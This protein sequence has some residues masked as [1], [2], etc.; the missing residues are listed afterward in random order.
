MPE[1]EAYE[2]LLLDVMNGDASQFMRRDQV[3][4]AWKIVMPILEYWEEQGHS[5]LPVYPAGTWGPE[6]AHFLTARDGRVWVEPRCANG[7]RTGR[8]RR[9]R[10]GGPGV[11]PSPGIDAEAP[12]RSTVAII[13]SG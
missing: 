12:Y 4:E 7:R 9:R 8:R 11:G 10:R 1:P 2:T 6:A 13:A 3:E 5:D